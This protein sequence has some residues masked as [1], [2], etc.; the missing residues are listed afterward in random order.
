MPLE[1]ALCSDTGL[2]PYFERGSVS[3]N[4]ALLQLMRLIA[5]AAMRPKLP[6]A[7]SPVETRAP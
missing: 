4:P 1:R 2:W 6:P 5:K 3:V 7:Q